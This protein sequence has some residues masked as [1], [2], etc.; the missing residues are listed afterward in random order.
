MSQAAE[1]CRE[2][3]E[4]KYPGVRISRLACKDTTKGDISQHSAYDGYDSN[5]LDIMG[6]VGGSWDENVAFIQKIVD[7]LN[8]HLEEWSIRKILWQVAAH[9]GHA[10]IDFYP[11]IT[12]HKWCGGPETPTWR[13]SNGDTVTTRDPA[14]ENGPYDGSD[15]MGCPWTNIEPWKTDDPPCDNHYDDGEDIEWGVNTGVCNVPVWGKD[16]T[17]WA[18]ATGLVKLRD[19]NRDDFERQLTDGRYWMF[20]QRTR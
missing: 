3:I 10:H 13:L 6:V 17:R 14:P 7:D 8:Q 11:M 4:A 20:E 15:N 5:A 2:Y 19:N 12:M 18:I 1:Q 16:A 9:F